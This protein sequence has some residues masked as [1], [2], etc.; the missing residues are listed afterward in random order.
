MAAEAA[1][2]AAP[3]GL[4]W[5]DTRN[6]ALDGGSQHKRGTR[7]GGPAQCGEPRGARLP[8]K[9]WHMKGMCQTHKRLTNILTWNRS[10]FVRAL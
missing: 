6:T 5:G 9:E 10:V 7:K 1:D 8:H 2:S 4:W 3:L